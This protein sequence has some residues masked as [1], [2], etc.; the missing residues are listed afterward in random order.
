MAVI[1]ADSK[2]PPPPSY[3]DVLAS[4][5]AEELALL[6]QIKRFFE[7]Y[8]GD[9]GLRDSLHRGAVT[10][11]QR[12]LLKEI[13]VTF[14]VEALAPMWTHREQFVRAQFELPVLIRLCPR[15]RPH[16]QRITRGR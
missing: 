16:A 5:T 4:F 3:V 8:E 1:D 13:G 9:A 11:A 2:T 15:P 14:E 12:A 6:P 10:D 7:C